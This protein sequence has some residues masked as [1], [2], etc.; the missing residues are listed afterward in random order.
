MGLSVERAEAAE[1]DHFDLFSTPLFAGIL[2]DF[3]PNPFTSD[4]AARA[5]CPR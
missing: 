1:Y 5:I 4:L 3:L 2:A